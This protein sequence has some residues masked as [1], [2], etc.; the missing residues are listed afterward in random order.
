M[1]RIIWLE[2]M[3]KGVKYSTITYEC[4]TCVHRL[5]TDGVK[6]YEFFESQ[7]KYKINDFS[8]PKMQAI[9]KILYFIQNVSK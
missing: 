2:Q 8:S 7:S 1:A 4:V 9:D 6:Y 5:E 3:R